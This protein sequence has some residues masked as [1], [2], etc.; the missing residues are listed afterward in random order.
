M[1]GLGRRCRGPGHVFVTLGR[2]TA[3]QLR[4][5]G[6]ARQTFGLQAK[7]RL[8]HTITLRD[9]PH[10]RLSL[11]LTPALR[12]H[13]H[14]CHQSQ[15][16]PSGTKLRHWKVV[17]AYDPT[18]A[19]MVK[20]KSHGPAQ[21]GRK[22]G[23]ASD[24]ASGLL[25]ATLVPQGNPSAPS[26]GLPLIDQGHSA[27]ER[28]HTGPKRRMHSVAG[29][30]G[31]NDPPW[32]QALHER[33]MLTVGMP[34]T[35]APLE[36]HPRAQDI[37]AILNE[38][39]LHRMRTPHH[40]PVA[41]ASGERRPVVESPIASLLSRGAGQGRYKGLAGAVVHQGMTVMAHNGAVLVRIRHKRLSK[42]AQTFRR[43]LRLKSPKVN[44]I[45]HQRN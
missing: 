39:G 1:R 11:A 18:I 33:G 3:Q 24:P 30:L 20:G 43:L 26:Y 42:R 40:V 31:S 38:A 5:L 28:V 13:A 23:I 19:P 2:Q 44:E 27:I 36:V 34:Q 4:A 14:I 29:A 6:E 15:R 9:A 10:Q 45:N 16:L 22:P 25:C 35:I 7:E 37:R 17:N 32:R 21:V 8:D 12:H 41:C